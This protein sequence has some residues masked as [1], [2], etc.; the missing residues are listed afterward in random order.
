MTK[1]KL[2]C[3]RCGDNQAAKKF[4]FLCDGELTKVKES[5]QTLFVKKLCNCCG[6][7]ANSFLNYYGRKKRKDI[8]QLND[9]LRS[10]LLSKQAELNRY[11]QL[12]NA[13]YY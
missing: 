10:G 11:N 7:K 12:N 4:T 8:K 1:V 9:Y 2:I 3:D 5:Y 13:G 6:E